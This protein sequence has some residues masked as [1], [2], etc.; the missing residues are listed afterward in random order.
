V[1]TLRSI[2]TSAVLG[3]MFFAAQN[4][5]ATGF[6]ELG[7]DIVQ[8][9]KVHVD[10]DGYLRVR[11][12]AL[13]NLDLDR[14]FTPSGQPLFP[15]SKADPTA[16]TLTHWDMRARMDVKVFAPGSTLAVKLRL[17]ALDNLSLGSVPDGAPSATVSQRSPGDPLKVRRAY[18]EALLPFGVLV[19]GRMGTHWGLGLVANSGD[20][21]DCDSADAQDR[22]ALVTPIA[23]HVFAV[24]YDF[25][26]TGPVGTRPAQNRFLDLERSTNVRTATL[27]FLRGWSKE[28]IARRKKADKI[29]VDYGGYFTH[30]WQSN[31]VPA[32]YLP[33]AQPLDASQGL[34][35][36][37]GLTATGIDAWA[38][39]VTQKLRLEAEF[40]MVLSTIEQASVIPGVLLRD[41]VKARQIGA[42]FESDYGSDDGVLA[43]GI[44]F[45]YASGDPAP[46]FGVVQKPGGTAPKP[47]DLDGAQANPRSDNRIDNF[48]FHPDYR[49]DRILFREIIGTVTDATYVRPHARVRFVDKTSYRV[50][51]TAAAVASM[52]NFAESTP[53]GKKPLGIEI[54]PSLTYE[55][56]DGFFST[57]DYAVLFPLSGLDNPQ[58]GLFAKPAQLVRVR[59]SYVF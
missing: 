34:V 2:T 16:Q 28:S 40:S 23:N 55:H 27:A 46:G 57:L 39:L 10:V 3:A 5:R 49:I 14:G 54:D 8:R 11:G 4:A 9:D 30:R 50:T 36:A 1:K 43:G 59:F 15:V 12:E 29:T 22:V 53:G 41:P 19:A 13:N 58:S 37:R 17:D 26:A 51:A 32:S 38:K 44:D 33:T 52:A 7:E 45:G 42:A 20:C 48:R 56:K 25:S 24:A 31:D 6:A 21:L 18:G 35:M 47:G